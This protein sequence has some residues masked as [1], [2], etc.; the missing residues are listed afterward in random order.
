MPEFKNSSW[1][2]GTKIG[3]SN[4]QFPKDEHEIPTH[5]ESIERAIAK[6][7][8]SFNSIVLDLFKSKII[9]FFIVSNIIQ[10]PMPNKS[11]ILINF[12]TFSGII[13]NITLP[14]KIEMLEKSIDKK[15]KTVADNLPIVVFLIPYVMPIP[16]ESILTDIARIN[17]AKN[18]SLTSKY[19]M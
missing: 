11:I 12:T 16:K 1:N 9:G 10:I 19:N 14:R 7:K 3:Y 5:T 17:I 15:N 8:A 2:I 18:K 13:E 6:Q 4:P